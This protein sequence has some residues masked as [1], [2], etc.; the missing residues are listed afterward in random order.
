MIHKKSQKIIKKKTGDNVSP[1][2]IDSLAPDLKCHR[3][4]YMDGKC[5]DFFC[6][7]HVDVLSTYGK[8]ITGP[9][10]VLKSTDAH[11]PT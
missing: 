6:V 1:G 7:L 11:V 9:P 8:L 5:I 2:I 4:T 10:Q 3:F